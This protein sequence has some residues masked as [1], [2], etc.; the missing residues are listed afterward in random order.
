MIELISFVSVIINSAI[1]LF[2]SNKV[3]KV[4][5]NGPFFFDKYT[6]LLII[7]G[8]E[9]GLILLKFIVIMLYR[10]VGDRFFEKK[11]INHFLLK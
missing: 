6:Y 1:V 3:E 11:T 9:H 10:G 5:L 4:L 8:C 7:I 2:T